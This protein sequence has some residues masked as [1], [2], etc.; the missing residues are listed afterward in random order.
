MKR[1]YILEA[2]KP[3]REYDTA[4]AFIVR[5]K[6]V[7]SARIMAGLEAGDEGMGAWHN[8]KL[9]SCKILKDSGKEQIILRDFN[10][11]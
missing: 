10:A 5:A 11:G 8:P 7:K 4:A 1:L 3:W 2:K 6:N 9:T